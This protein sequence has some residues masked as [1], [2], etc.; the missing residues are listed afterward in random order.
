MPTADRRAGPE[1]LG[2][3]PPRRG[4]ELGSR[5]WGGAPGPGVPLHFCA[6][7]TLPDRLSST[8]EPGGR[9]EDG[10]WRAHQSSAQCPLQ[11]P[12]STWLP[13]V[14]G[15]THQG[16]QRHKALNPGTC[17]CFF[18]CKD[19][20]DGTKLRTVGGEVI[21]DYPGVPQRPSP[22]LPKRAMSHEQKESHGTTEAETAARRPQPRAASCCQKRERARVESPPEPPE[23]PAPCWPPDSSPRY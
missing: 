11:R 15:H 7:C 12:F 3:V 9:R 20:V 18:S 4:A 5:P 16:P 13:A 23:G 17:E 1:N 8:S 6:A 21:L 14:A 22:G 19:F 2:E 10:P